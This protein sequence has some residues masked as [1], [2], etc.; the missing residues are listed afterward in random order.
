MSDL[1]SRIEIG[2]FTYKIKERKHV[3]NDRGEPL[4][5]K[6]SFQNHVIHIRKSLTP[7]AKRETLI[8][9]ILHGIWGITVSALSDITPTEEHIV[10][11]MSPLILTVLQKNPD[12]AKFILGD[13]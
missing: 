2:P 9:E 11:L 10:Y 5:G 4:D 7:Q 12:V 8:H 13:K 1:P 6:L 3:V